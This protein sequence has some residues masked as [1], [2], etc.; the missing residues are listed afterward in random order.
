MWSEFMEVWKSTENSCETQNEMV[1]YN[2]RNGSESMN[3]K[4]FDIKNFKIWLKSE[5][6][7]LEGM[8]DKNEQ[9]TFDKGRRNGKLK[10]LQLV[11]KKLKEFE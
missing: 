3:Q 8:I 11:Q 1:E 5:I 2:T 4:E 9:Q 6:E 10:G 7:K